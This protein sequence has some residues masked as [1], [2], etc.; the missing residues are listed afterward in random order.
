MVVNGSATKSIIS[1]DQQLPKN[2]T[3]DQ[4]PKTENQQKKEDV[5]TMGRQQ[6]K[7][8]TCQK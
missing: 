5:G 1:K 6:A 4:K 8:Q 3:K 7:K 2:E